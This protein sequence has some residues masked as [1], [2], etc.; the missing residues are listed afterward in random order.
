MD[1]NQ[2]YAMLFDSFGRLGHPLP[3][4]VQDEITASTYLETFPK[5]HVILPYNEVCRNVYFITKGLVMI[6]FNYGEKD[7]ICWFLMESDVFISVESFFFEVQSDF[8]IVTLENTQCI[9]MPRETL[10]DIA[11]RHRSFEKVDKALTRYYYAALE[12][13]T[14]LLYMSAIDRCTQMFKHYR[15]IYDRV[16][17]YHMAWYLGMEQ[18]TFSNVQK[19]MLRDNGIS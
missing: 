3:Q 5:D 1:S 14:K 15:Q 4:E 16:N 13:K 17:N 9:V 2:S 11:E 6:K 8:S 19:Q 12:R 7:R 10:D 18:Q